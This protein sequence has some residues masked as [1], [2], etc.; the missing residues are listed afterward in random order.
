MTIKT[1]VPGQ[2]LEDFKKASGHS[3]IT[4]KEWAKRGLPI[5][6]KDIK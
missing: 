1:P 5:E 2:T 6:R 4:K 3:K